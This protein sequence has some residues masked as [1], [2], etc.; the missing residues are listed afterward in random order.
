[1]I[2]AIISICLFASIPSIS[3]SS[4]P[5]TPIS[6]N[7]A[8][9]GGSGNPIDDC[10][11]RCDPGWADDRQRLADCGVGFGRD[12]VGGGK[13]GRLYVVNDSS[14]DAER[15]GTLRHGLGQDEALWIVFA[16]DMTIRPAHELVVRPRK[17]VDGRGA[18]VVVGDGGACFAVRGAR[19]VVIHGITI[20]GCRPKPKAA[21]AADESMGSSSSHDD[22][23]SDGDGVSVINSTDVWIDHC[24][25]EDCADGLIDVVEGST[26]VTL[27]NNLLQNHDKA[28]LLGHSDEYTDDAAMRVTVAFNRFG[29]GLVQR[30]PR[31]RF[32]LFHV[33][34][35]D[36]IDWEMYAVGG[37]SAPT[38]VSHGNRF[39]ADKAKEV[40]KRDGDAPES[41][42]C[43]W[44]WIS[45]GDLMLNGAFFKTSGK[46]GPDLKAPSFARS[47][48]SVPSITSSA[49]ALSCKEGSPC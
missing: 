37:S 27:S 39:S 19:D 5:P 21:A 8:S 10:W 35:N 30:M 16:R 3:S 31:C 11:R 33:I 40:T 36:Y 1:M 25:F 44:N 47:A 18:R 49:G 48:S 6:T 41:V 24:T 20:R 43:K 13:G 34:N 14:D 23:V 38:I 12:A 45:E 4:S 7:N 15:P 9:C 28:M 22:D 29:P 32:G 42:W 26:R 17:T 2:L 46:A